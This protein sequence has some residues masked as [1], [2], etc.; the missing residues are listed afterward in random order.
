VL[1]KLKS[2]EKYEYPMLMDPDLAWDRQHFLEIGTFFNY[3]PAPYTRT[4][5]LMFVPRYVLKNKL[6]YPIVIKERNGIDQI[7]LKPNSEKYFNLGLERDSGIMIRAL[8]LEKEA[9][10]ILNSVPIQSESVQI[11]F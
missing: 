2:A 11:E 5:L 4:K 10:P 3:C 7:V 8:D 6:D 1:K 9:K